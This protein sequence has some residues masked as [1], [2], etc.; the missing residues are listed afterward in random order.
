MTSERFV[1]RLM[2]AAVVGFCFSL[3]AL[4]L[5]EAG[6]VLVHGGYWP[7]D[8]EATA[9]VFVAGLAALVLSSHGYWTRTEIDPRH[10]PGAVYGPPFMAVVL[11]IFVLGV[12]AMFTVHPGGVTPTAAPG[13]ARPA[14]PSAAPFTP[15]LPAVNRD[16]RRQGSLAVGWSGRNSAE[17][18][19]SGQNGVAEESF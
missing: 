1:V 5:T 7:S 11:L 13:A 14:A 8:P 19:I 2:G 4:T 12:T 16:L 9:L 18:Q 6:V 3:M 15:Q 17:K 10:R